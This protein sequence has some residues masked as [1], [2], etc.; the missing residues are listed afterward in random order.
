M[1]ASA[2]VVKTEKWKEKLNPGEI[3]RENQTRPAVFRQLVNLG[4]AMLDVV[5]TGK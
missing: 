3:S 1:V 4:C 2:R 5:S